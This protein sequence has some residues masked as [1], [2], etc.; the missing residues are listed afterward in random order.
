MNLAR[1]ITESALTGKR[2]ACV[3]FPSLTHGRPFHLPVFRSRPPAGTM[4]CRWG[5]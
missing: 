1:N 2:K 4:Q 3:P 5:W